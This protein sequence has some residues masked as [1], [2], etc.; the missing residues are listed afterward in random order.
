MDISAYEYVGTAT[1]KEIEGILLR[2]YTL[3]MILLEKIRALCQTMPGYQEIIKT[4]QQKQRARD[5]Y[6][7]F[8][9]FNSGT[10][11]LEENTLREIFKA[12]KCLWL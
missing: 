3:E 1:A 4:A 6:D 5:I 10:L 8:T 12:K 11:S 7:I 2:V 9:V